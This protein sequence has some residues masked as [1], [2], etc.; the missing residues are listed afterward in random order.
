MFKS[1]TISIFSFF[2]LLFGGCAGQPELYTAL[3]KERKLEN[4]LLSINIDKEE[5][6]DISKKAISYSLELAKEYELV[7]PPLYHNFLV[8]IGLKKRGLC[9]QFA[10]DL[11]DYLKK[12]NY[13]SVDFYIGGANINDYWSEHNVVVLTCKGC[14]FR[15]G[16]LLDAWRDSG[17][18]FFSKLK[19]DKIYKWKQRGGI[20]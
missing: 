17:N 11:L 12:Q 4:L 7:K 16:V 10:Y 6:K 9:W 18:L 14:D 20:R 8:N 5:A 1:L 15:Q 2:I 13:K 19:E 3:Q